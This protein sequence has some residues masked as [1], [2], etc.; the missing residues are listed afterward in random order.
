MSDITDHQ[1]LNEKHD[2]LIV[3]YNQLVRDL[4]AA[5]AEVEQLRYLLQ[6]E[7]VGGICAKLKAEVAA[8]KAENERLAKEIAFKELCRKQLVEINRRRGE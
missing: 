7:N 4:T 1:D 2:K 6:Y 8:L 3:K 5:R